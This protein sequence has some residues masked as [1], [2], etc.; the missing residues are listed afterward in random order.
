M[1]PQFS[2]FA[3]CVISFIGA[4]S[5]TQAAELMPAAEQTALIQ[6]YCGMCHQ[7]NKFNRGGLSLQH[8]DASR[9]DPTL[10]VMLAAK[11]KSG[12][13]YAAGKPTPPDATVNNLIASLEIEGAGAEKWFATTPADP[14]GFRISIVR[15]ADVK[16][17]EGTK[18]NYFRLIVRCDSAAHTATMQ[19]TWAPI[20]PLEDSVISVS[21]DQA[22]PHEFK[23]K[24]SGAMANGAMG[25]IG[26]LELRTE[27]GD[28]M[29]IPSRSLVFNNLPGDQTLV[30]PFQDLSKN[31]RARLSECSG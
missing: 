6:N 21:A 23:L 5:A 1:T 27:R 24:N 29:P 10:A 4:C 16:S 11:L 9:V 17:A 28:P 13:I 31:V 19:L 20:N 30:F 7:E 25:G 22:A 14:E 12:A 15:Q 26:N 18:P 8:F 2:C 3:A